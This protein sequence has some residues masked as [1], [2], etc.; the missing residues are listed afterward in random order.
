LIV[1]ATAATPAKVTP[2]P[3]AA[4]RRLRTIK[5]TLDELRALEGKTG[6]DYLRVR[7][8]ESARVGLGDEVRDLFPEAVK[9]IVEHESL[10]I[11]EVGR[12]DRAATTPHDLFVEYLAHKDVSDER[13]VALFDELHEEVHASPS[14]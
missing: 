12:A 4:G 7:V 5:G 11:G 2:V 1:E 9:V 13:L 10:P 6:D 8:N 3:L 14:S